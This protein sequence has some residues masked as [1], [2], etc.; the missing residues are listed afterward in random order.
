VV[1]VIKGIKGI[2]LKINT[3]IFG[4]CCG[5]GYFWSSDHTKMYL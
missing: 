4:V 5:L 3:K 2:E 1:S